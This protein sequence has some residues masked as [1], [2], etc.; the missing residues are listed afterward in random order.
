MFANI[1]VCGKKSKI[2]K[3]WIWRDGIQCSEVQERRREG[4]SL[5]N[6]LKR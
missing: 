5:R 2:Q 3:H 6:I 4:V 1:H